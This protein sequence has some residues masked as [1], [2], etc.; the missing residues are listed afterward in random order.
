VLLLLK[1]KE[2]DVNATSAAAL[3]GETALDLAK[4][5]ERVDVV[6]LLKSCG[7]KT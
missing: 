6:V 1:E 4:K 7:A 3:G 2:A 5:K